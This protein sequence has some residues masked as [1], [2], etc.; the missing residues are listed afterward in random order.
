M[1]LAASVV[2]IVATVLR[3]GSPLRASGLPLVAE[4]FAAALRPELDPQF[5]QLT[6]RAALTTVAYALLG[7]AL[8]LVFGAVGGLLGSRLWWRTGGRRPVPGRRATAGWTLTRLGLVLP[9]GVHEI[10][11]GLFLL[12]V[13]GTEPIVAVLAIAIPFGAITAKV[14]AEIL[15]DADPRAA[16][17][18]LAAGASRG[19]AFCYAVLPGAATELVSY[20]FYRLD[21]AIRSAA[22]L[23]LIGAGGLGFQLQLS[24]ASLRYEQIW[25]LLYTLIVLT[26]LADAWSSAVRSRLAARTGRDRAGRDPVLVASLAALAAALPVCAIAIDLSVAPLLDGRSWA[27]IG[28]LFA[29]SFPPTLGSGRAEA[30]GSGAGGAWGLLELSAATLAMSLLA[31]AVAFLAGALLAGPAARPPAGSRRRGRRAGAV[32]VRLLL[33]TLRAIPPPVWALVLLFVFEPGILPGALALG[34]YTAGVLGRLMGESVENTDPRPVAALRAQGASAGGAFTYG[35]LPAVSRRFVGYGC[36]RWEVTI[37]ETV[38]VGVVGA[39]GLGM[40]LHTQVALFDYAG[41]AS[42][43]GALILLSVLV[44]AAGVWLRRRIG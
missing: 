4:F 6:G 40:L 16:D 28:E 11:W 42:T 39:G 29:E 13:L 9:R 34:I 33:V 37:R 15:D 22:I 43:L 32:L 24:F 8:S 26:L 17:A 21:C 3:D 1:A 41:A 23:G 25:T 12:A 44:D 36:Y 10:V 19:G 7:T 38:I 20:A 2:G 30:G 5:L 35:V 18:L 27:L 14:F 31:I